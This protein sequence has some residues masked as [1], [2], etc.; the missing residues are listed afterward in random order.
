MRKMSTL[1]T[2]PTTPTRTMTY[3]SMADTFTELNSLATATTTVWNPS[4][5]TDHVST[6]E[7]V[8]VDLLLEMPLTC[9]NF[10]FDKNHQPSDPNPNPDISGIGVYTPL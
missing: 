7:Y 9:E 4:P 8:Q 10:E 5:T 3:I 2:S 6:I 1:Q